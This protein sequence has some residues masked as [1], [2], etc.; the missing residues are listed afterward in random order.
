MAKRPIMDDVA[1]EAGVSR[2]LVS[3]AFRNAP[4]VS[5]ATRQHILEVANRIGYR[6]NMMASQLASLSTRTLGVILFDMGNDLTTDVFRGIQDEADKLDFGLLVGVSDSTGKRDKR[7][8]EYLIEARVEAILLISSAMAGSELRAMSRTTPVVSLT[9]QV[10]GIDSVV[11]DGM[12]GAQ[13]AVEHL[14]G[15]GHT[16]IDHLA[17]AWRPSHRVTGYE[18][19][20]RKA[21]LTPRITEIT[22]ERDDAARAAEWLLKQ[23]EPPTAIFANNDIAAQGVL[24]A[25][26]ETRLRV[27]DDVA[28]VGYDNLRSSASKLISLT[29]VDQQAFRLGQLGVQTAQARIAHPAASPILRVLSPELVIRRSTVG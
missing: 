19:A 3:L 2:T 4:G 9:R 16:R 20:M 13:L 10:N 25:L 5:E 15:L 8:V 17:P 14:V 24:D 21:G 29:S 23:A 26:Y 22:Y 18:S 7:T 12:A 6:R 1:R 11:C 27:P 28:V